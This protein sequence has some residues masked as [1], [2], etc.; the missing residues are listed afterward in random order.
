MKPFKGNP[1][2]ATANND[3]DSEEDYMKMTFTDTPQ[4]TIPETSLQRRQR[5]RREAEA[6]SRPKSKS[7]MAALEAAAREAALSKSLLDST[8]KKSKGLAMMAKMGFK[9]GGTLG[10]KDNTSAQAEPIR[11]NLK[12]GREGLGL[13][14]ENKRKQREAYEKAGESAKK[15]KVDYDE[16]R[17][18][19]LKEAKE[20]RLTGLLQQ[21]QKVAERMDDERF[22]RVDQLPGNVENS[23]EEEVKKKKTEISSRP[24]KSLPVVYRSLVRAREQASRLFRMRH[25]LVQSSESR[26]LPGYTDP[27]EDADYKMA[28]GIR[29][30][31]PVAGTRYVTADDL[32]DEDEELDEF[33]ALEV[34][35]KLHRVVAYLREQHRYCFW[36]KFEYP[37]EEME[38]CPGT[39]EEDHD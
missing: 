6:R 23:K 11:I 37:D 25:D 10:S 38:G 3:S 35:E 33:E 31:S 28:L 17:E 15:V 34:E 19:T 18:R 39:E 12:D 9:A 14:S 32:D 36:C 8:A 27:D 2:N 7:E 13:E 16:F 30:G 26:A 22:G 21:A 5:E 29:S 4:A 1:D 20:K 24:L